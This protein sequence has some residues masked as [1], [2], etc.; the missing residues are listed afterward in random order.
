MKRFIWTKWDRKWK[1]FNIIFWPS[2]IGFIWT[3]WDRKTVFSPY[4]PLWQIR[5]IWTKWDRKKGKE[6][7]DKVVQIASFIWTKWDRKIKTPEKI[8][9][10]LILVLSELSGIERALLFQPEF[11]WKSVLSELSGIES[12]IINFIAL[13]VPSFYLN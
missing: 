12:P 8:L 2:A 6:I 11:A 10:V 4:P 9:R 7:F 1:P 3:K 5:F 13:F